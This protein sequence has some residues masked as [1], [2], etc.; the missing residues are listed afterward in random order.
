MQF[1]CKNRKLFLNCKLP[2]RVTTINSGMF[3]K[4]YNLTLI[5]IPE[6]VT[7]VGNYAFDYCGNLT[8]FAKAES[9]PSNWDSDRNHSN[10]PVLYS[11]VF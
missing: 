3:R 11:A 5:T 10:R 6:G 9:K 2:E 7:T 1:L 4:C 8:I